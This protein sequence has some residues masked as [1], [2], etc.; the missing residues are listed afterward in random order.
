MLPTLTLKTRILLVTLSVLVVAVIASYIA[1]SVAVN[2]LEESYS[3]GA[4]NSKHALWN[5]SISQQVTKMEVEVFALTRNKA[6]IAALK[7]DSDPDLVAAL[8]PTYNRL[9]AVGTI[10]TLL[11]TNDQGRILYVNG[12]NLSKSSTISLVAEALGSGKLQ[13]GI[14]KSD[15]SPYLSAFI[16]PLYDGPGELVG[17]GVLIKNLM[18]VVND[19]KNSA[20]MDVTVLDKKGV[21]EYS[22]NRD[23]YSAVKIKLPPNGESF[24]DTIK[25]EGEVYSVVV[26]PVTNEARDA[27]YVVGI[28]EYTTQYKNI[29]DIKF[30]SAIIILVT[31]LAASGLLYW[32]IHRSLTPLGVVADTMSAIAEGNLSNIVTMDSDDEIGKLTRS[33]RTMQSNLNGMIKQLQEVSDSLNAQSVNLTNISN[34]TKEGMNEQANETEMVV[35]AVTEMSSSI[36]EVARNA[37]A[38]AIAAQKADVE[39]RNG[40]EVVAQT[41][42]VINKLADDVENAA[43]VINELESESLLISAVLDVIKNIAEQT[44]LLALNA[45]IEAA[46][47]GEQGRGFAVVAD[48]VRTLATRTQESTNEI[49]EMI[50]RLQHGARNAVAVM[51][52]GR[53]QAHAGMEQAQLSG[54]SLQCITST[55]SEINDMNTQIAA[56]AQEQSSVA[57]EINKNIVN[58]SNLAEQSLEGSNQTDGTSLKI[59]ALAQQLVGHIRNFKTA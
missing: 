26:H 27:G 13:R 32:L 2:S 25:V 44:N 30:I 35:T 8:E 17:A 9:Q 46:R 11:V 1:N 22:T 12:G 16:V 55:I 42:T 38:A 7:S 48:E 33:A 53:K 28:E 36:D 39:A 50:E 54:K 4:I 14:L 51:E 34:A 21:I 18:S 57:S 47:A 37:N 56:A 41:I 31:V 45:A 3:A 10:D 23:L 43:Q 15:D 58:I 19:L 49:H 24:L 59:N 40:A 5:K 20:D 29:T 52:K 6:M